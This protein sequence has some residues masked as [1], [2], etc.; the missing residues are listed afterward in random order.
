M[1]ILVTGL[2]RRKGIAK[3]SGKPYE[4]TAIHAVV[5]LEQIDTPDVVVRGS[6]GTT[7]ERV[8]VAL[9]RKYENHPLPFEADLVVEDVMRFGKR[10]AQVID[11]RPVVVDRTT[12]E[13]VPARKAA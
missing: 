2:E 8:P 4:M 1:R 3:A 13:V 5:K 7:Y 9:I 11:L 12:G 10:E 6:M